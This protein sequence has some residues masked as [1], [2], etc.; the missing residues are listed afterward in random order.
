[1]AKIA[2]LDDYQGAALK[3][4]DWSEV[5][6]RAEVVVFHDHVDDADALVER[7]RPFDAICVLRE[8]TPL[9]AEILS[10]LPNL[11]FIGSNAPYNASIDIK[12]ANANG[13]VVSYTGGRGNGAP[14][15]AWALILAAARHIPAEVAALRSGQWQI[16]VGTD[17]EGSTLGIMGLGRV[18]TRMAAVARAFGMKVIAWSENLTAEKASEAG[19]TLVDKQTLLKEA[20]WLTLH[21]VLSDRTRG[22]VGKEELAS[23]KPSAWLVNTS[24]GPLVDEAALT[25][26]LARRSIAGAALDVFDIEP[27]PLDHPFRGLDN[28]VATS[29]VGFVTKGTYDIFF[30]ETVENVLAWLDGAPIRLMT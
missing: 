16:S 10:R 15:L 21:L 27:L 19:V 5:Q 24:R 3:S 12:A 26:A 7:L 17:L 1:M 8:R 2:I 14:E 9:T 6:A 25:D 4:A 30:G 28:V 18:G 11:K 20:D 29:H 23:M 13:I 22:I